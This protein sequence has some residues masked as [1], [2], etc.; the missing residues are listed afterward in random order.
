MPS[1]STFRSASLRDVIQSSP[2]VVVHPLR[3][4]TQTTLVEDPRHNITEPS[5]EEKPLTRISIGE[6][7]ESS[8]LA[9]ASSKLSYRKVLHTR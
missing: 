6:S 7:Y 5:P 2:D 9:Y 3:S 1:R 4:Q 8:D